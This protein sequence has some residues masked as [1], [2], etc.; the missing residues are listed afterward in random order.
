M[1]IR[2]FTGKVIKGS[3]MFS[4]IKFSGLVY[5][6]EFD[7]K[8]ISLLVNNIYFQNEGSCYRHEFIAYLLDIYFLQVYYN[9]V[10]IICACVKLL[11]NK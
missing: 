10:V 4:C 8:L 2:A 7:E 11:F 5:D 6:A 3:I 1:I 9:C